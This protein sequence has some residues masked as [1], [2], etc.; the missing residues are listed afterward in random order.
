MKTDALY[1]LYLDLGNAPSLA[2]CASLFRHFIADFG[3]D[4]FACGEFDLRDRMRSVFYIIDWPDHWRDFYIQSGLIHH[5]PLLDALPTATA[6]FTWSDLRGTRK[7]PKAGREALDR[8]ADAGWTE[9][10]VVPIPTSGNRLGLVSLAGHSTIQ[11]EFRATLV[12]ASICLHSAARAR[13]RRD[14][15]AQPPVNLTKRELEVLTLVAVGKSDDRIAQ[16]IGIA[17]STAHEFVENAKRKLNVR[18]RAEMIAIASAL[19]I[20]EI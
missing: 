9:G 10:L 13:A 15:F 14:G 17:P 3:F 7:F 4:T 20:I 12:F 16:T 5:D 1:A 6:P 18:T 19:G 11:Q 8:V 2:E